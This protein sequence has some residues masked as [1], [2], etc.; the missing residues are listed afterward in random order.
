MKQ[1]CIIGAS[2][3]LGLRFTVDLLISGHQVFGTYFSDPRAL[4][5]LQKKFDTLQIQPLALTE[6]SEIS[7]PQDHCDT[8]IISAG[9]ISNQLVLKESTPNFQ[10]QITCNLTAV[11]ELCQKMYKLLR[12]STN[13]HIILI[14]SGSALYGNS[15]QAAYSAAKAGLLGLGKTLAKEWARANIKVNLVSPGYLRSR[16]TL[17]NDKML[18]EKYE[19]LNALGKTNTLKEISGF[20]QYLITSLEIV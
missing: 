6:V 7:Y 16:Q 10:R 18:S 9:E 20:I 13:P 4:H 19:T 11:F 14:T 2:S 15:G 12:K 1:T 3:G 5:G 8:L 17:T